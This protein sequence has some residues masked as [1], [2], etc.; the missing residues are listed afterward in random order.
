MEEIKGLYIVPRSTLKGKDEFHVSGV[1]QTSQ[2]PEIMCSEHT[3]SY[4]QFDILVIQC[5]NGKIYLWQ[6]DKIV[7]LWLIRFYVYSMCLENINWSFR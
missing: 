3:V 4:T 2:K 5:Y 7:T 6:A 1:L